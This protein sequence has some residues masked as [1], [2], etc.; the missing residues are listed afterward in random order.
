MGFNIFGSSKGIHGCLRLQPGNITVVGL[1]IV[2]V[3]I[4]ESCTA[5]NSSKINEAGQRF[6]LFLQ[7]CGVFLQ[8]GGV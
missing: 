4:Y 5:F 7:P 1:S 6:F 8:S 3:W 2:P